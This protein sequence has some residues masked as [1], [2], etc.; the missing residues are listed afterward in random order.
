MHGTA[1]GDIHQPGDL[2]RRERP[3]ER[4]LA[5]DAVEP[6]VLRLAVRAVLDVDAGVPQP[7][8]HAGQRPAFALR[9][10]AQGHGGAGSERGQ[11]EVVGVGPAVRA[12]LLGRLV[13]LQAGAAP[14]W[15]C[16]S[17]PGLPWTTTSPRS[18]MGV[19]SFLTSCSPAR[20]PWCPFRQFLRAAAG[21]LRVRACRLSRRAAA[22]ALSGCSASERSI[23][24]IA[25]VSRPS[26]THE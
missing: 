2:L 25:S 20:P 11:Q 7:D 8:R 4:D 16:V 13:T 23:H 6:R 10:E 18:G 12:A 26:R 5:V 9:V 22:D 19:T 21:Q 24:S 14:R 1:I 3:F 15:I 17:T